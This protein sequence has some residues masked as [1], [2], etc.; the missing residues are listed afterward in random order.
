MFA[1]R[2]FRGAPLPPCLLRRRRV[3]LVRPVAVGLASPDSAAA[4]LFPLPSVPLRRLRRPRPGAGRGW[5]GVV[6][7]APGRYGGAGVSSVLCRVGCSRIALFLG[8]RCGC[9]SGHLSG[10]LLHSRL[11]LLGVAGAG[12]CFY[13]LDPTSRLLP[14]VA[15]SCTLE[16]AVCCKGAWRCGGTASEVSAATPPASSVPLSADSAAF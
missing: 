3:S 12:W 7:A 8:I 6:Q 9:C 11:I 1:L 16:Y 15:V 14:P 4:S 5:E 10:P 13:S 2:R